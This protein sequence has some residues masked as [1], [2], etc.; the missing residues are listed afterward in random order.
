MKNIKINISTILA[1]LTILIF[2][3]IMYL[4]LFSKNTGQP[5]S[6]LIG[7]D[8]PSFVLKTF[9]NESINFDEQSDK[10]FVINFWSSWCIPCKD[11]TAVLNRA[12]IRYSND[13][14]EFV[15]VNIWDVEKNA[16]NFLKSYRTN[17]NNGYDPTK[18]IHV[19]YGIQG[20]PET[21]FINK[22]G[23]II[24]RFQGEL[25]DNILNY[26]TSQLLTNNNENK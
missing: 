24:N 23:I 26:F 2:I 7:K 5:V 14:V 4:S 25:T 21:F 9:D 16:R 13:D 3:F 11:E 8:A 15:G 20:V 17:Y 19:D 18:Q 22:E 10:A 12:N 1:F 6:P